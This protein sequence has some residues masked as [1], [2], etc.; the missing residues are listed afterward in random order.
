MNEEILKTCTGCG[1]KKPPSDYH[2][3]KSKLD[4]HRCV[5]KACIATY[6]MTRYADNKEKILEARRK[7]YKSNPEKEK[8][9]CR[10]WYASN[11]DDVLA[12]ADRWRKENPEKRK[13]ITKRWGIKNRA[14][15]REKQAKIRATL[16]GALRGVM[17]TGINKSLRAGVKA[18]RKWE[19]LAGYTVDALRVHLEQKFAPGMTWGN[20]GTYWH[21]DHV[22]PLSAFNY[23]RPE[24][25]DFKKCWALKNLRPLRAAE[26][27]KKRDKVESPFQPSLTIAL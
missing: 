4:G 27:I 2:K 16:T 19:T 9:S 12:K 20:R 21:I 18:G 1:E 26:N 24:D 11:R 6:T 25:I 5:C 10:K 17:S 14:Y 8:E 23:E 13:A 15:Y 22:V 7:R 3:D